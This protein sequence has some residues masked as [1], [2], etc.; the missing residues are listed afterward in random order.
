MAT[1]GELLAIMQE[2]HLV[3]VGDAAS[4]LGEEATVEEKSLVSVQP[5]PVLISQADVLVICDSTARCC[6]TTF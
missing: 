4:Y 5:A 6:V 1:T 3:D 2:L